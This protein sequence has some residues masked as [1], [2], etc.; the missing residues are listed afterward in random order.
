M[1]NVHY[2]PS[3]RPHLPVCPVTC[4]T[5]ILGSPV[6]YLYR[7]VVCPLHACVMLLLY[8][9]SNGQR[10]CIRPTVVRVC[11]IEI[12]LE[13]EFDWRKEATTSILISFAGQHSSASPRAILLRPHSDA[14]KHERKEQRMNKSSE[15]NPR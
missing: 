4:F 8:V 2:G 3:T 11:S 10:T 15:S 5:S 14:R 1:Y 7:R 6:R 12:K 9:V 13:E